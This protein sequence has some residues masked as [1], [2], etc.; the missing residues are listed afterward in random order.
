MIDPVE[1]AGDVVKQGHLSSLRDLFVEPS[2]SRLSSE[3]LTKLSAL[4]D[5]AKEFD[6][7]SPVDWIRDFSNCQQLDIEVGN[8]NTRVGKVLALAEILK[9]TR[10]APAPE[11]R[12]TF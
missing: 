10:N 9:K 2:Q 7:D 8:E 5:I 6:P 11:K 12:R 3:Q 1:N 4:Y